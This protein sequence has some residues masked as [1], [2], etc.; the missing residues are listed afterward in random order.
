MNLQEVSTK[1][2]E[3]HLQVAQDGKGQKGFAEP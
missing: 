1:M 2:L 3:H